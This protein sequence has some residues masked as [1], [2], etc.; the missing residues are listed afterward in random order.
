MRKS[1]HSFIEFF[2][3]D[4]FRFIP[5]QTFKYLACGGSTALL[6]LLIY[7]ISY[8][9]IFHKQ[10]VPV[11]GIFIGAHIAA[12]LV[13]FSISFPMGFALSKYVVFTTSELRGRVQLFR[14]GLTVLSCIGLNYL[15]LKIF[16]D[17]FGWY[18]TPSKALT[19]ALVAVYSYFT[20]QYFSFK[21]KGK[22]T[23]PLESG[24]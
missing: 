3:F 1:I 20:Q 14:Y 15:F 16:V 6:D 5:L 21:V 22:T 10:P 19:T 2:Y 17:A 13:S 7:F 23:S 12:F 4:F 9:F 11:G 18:A 8:N 24:L